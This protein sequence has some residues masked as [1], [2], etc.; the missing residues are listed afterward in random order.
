MVA[1]LT[2]TGGRLA[3]G[4]RGLGEVLCFIFFGPVAVVGTVIVSC[5]FYSYEALWL[6]CASGFLSVA[7]LE[8]NNLRDL[9]GDKAAGKLTLAARFGRKLGLQIYKWCWFLAMIFTSFITY[10]FFWVW[11]SVLVLLFFG[12]RLTAHLS[13]AQPNDAKGH[14][15]ILAQTSFAQFIWALSVVFAA[16]LLYGV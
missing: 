11:L 13:N 2:Y 14:N 15:L 10:V 1:A 8:V 6:G 12:A 3:Y 4:Y 7:L 9:D 16:W 5:G